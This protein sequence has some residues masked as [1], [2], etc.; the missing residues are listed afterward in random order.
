MRGVAVALVVVAHLWPF[1]LPGGFVGVDVFFV[2]SGF[3]ITS[4]LVREIERT[5]RVALATFWARRA[6]RSFPRRSRCCW[7]ARWRRSRSSPRPAGCS[8]SAEI[9]AGAAYVE[10]WRL[11]ADA[12]D[13]F[14]SENGPSPVQ[15]YWSLSVEEQF[16]LVWPVALGAVAFLTTPPRRA[17]RADGSGRP[18]EPRLRPCG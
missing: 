15:H 9:R 18:G 4:H 3:L 5:R 17:G 13:Y 6:R 1:A 12:V 14:A 10:N 8:S 7:R 16:Y 2:I 11:A